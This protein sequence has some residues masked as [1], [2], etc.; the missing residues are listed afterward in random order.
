M[1]S[2]SIKLATLITFL[3]A[4]STFS[5]TTEKKQVAPITNEKV[6]FFDDFSE[7]ALDRTKWNV[8]VTHG[9]VNNEQQ[10]YVDSASTIYIAHGIEAAG[11]SDGVLVLKP[12]FSPGFKN[13]E[14]NSFD[15]ISGRI[16][17]RDK[18]KFTYGS[19]SARMKL[20]D[21]PGFWP[22]FWALGDGKW[23]DCGE[24]DIMENVGEPDWVSAALHGPGYFGE[25]PI[26]NKIFMKKDIT[27][28]H[29]YSV[30][31]TENSLIF[32]VD[33]ETYYRVTRPMIE[34][35]GKWAFD[36]PK[37]LIVNFALGGAYPAKTNGVKSP[38]NG[39]PQSA[40]DLIKAGKAKVLVDWVKITK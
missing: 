40:V 21:G 8:S 13:S 29:V 10:A 4:G 24:I 15:F 28:W 20:P 19:I 22:A 7:K 18:V 1:K 6:V 35:Y 14:G 17:S 31:W 25:T 34:A 37:Y 23:P 3:T 27:R 32:K 36:N 16:D 38:Y 39:L 12:K 5:Q 2:N 9:I 30:D 11:A 33:G 26:V